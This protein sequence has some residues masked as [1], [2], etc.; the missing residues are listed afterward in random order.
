VIGPAGFMAAPAHQQSCAEAWQR[1]EAELESPFGAVDLR[2]DDYRVSLR[3]AKLSARKF[4]I[5]L[6]IDGWFKGEWLFRDC[7]ERRRFLRP[8]KVSRYGASLV[9]KMT[10]VIGKRRAQSEYGE[11]I[12][13]FYANWDSFGALKRHLLRNNDS[14]VITRIGSQDLTQ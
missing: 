2:C 7:E 10:K 13:V 1:A 8:V 6:Y 4:T 14:V 5:A 3:V 11:K 9:K 12:T